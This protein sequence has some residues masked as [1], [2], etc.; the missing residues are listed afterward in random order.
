LPVFINFACSYLQIVNEN[1]VFVA[2][3]PI[4]PNSILSVKDINRLFPRGS[5]VN[6]RVTNIING[7]KIQVDL[8]GAQ[9]MSS[10]RSARAIDSGAIGADSSAHNTHRIKVPKLPFQWDQPMPEG[11]LNLTQLTIGTQFPMATVVAIMEY[12][13]FVSCNV[14]RRGKRGSIA[15]VHGK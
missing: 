3:Y 4:D 14:Y 7:S 13:A 1:D 5:R 10:P 12:G 8:V 15:K 11:G 2:A 6:V 9:G